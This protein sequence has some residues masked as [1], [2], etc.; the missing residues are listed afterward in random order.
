M[1]S[2][3][4]FATIVG[5]QLRRPALA[6]AQMSGI[7]G[8]VLVSATALLFAPA[9]LG[10]W[11]RRGVPE[12]DAHVRTWG[13]RAFRTIPWMM[14]IIALALFVSIPP[15]AEISPRRPAAKVGAALVPGSVVA[16]SMPGPSCRIRA[17]FH[18]S[19]WELRTASEFCPLARGDAIY[20]RAE[21]L[22]GAPVV[23]PRGTPAAQA[24]MR[25][26]V[27][28]VAR[29]SWVWRRPLGA[30]TPPQVLVHAW[31]HAIA[32]LRHRAWTWS[33]G[34]TGRSLVVGASLGIPAALSPEEV[35]VLRA[36][37]LSHLLAV[38]GLHVGVAFSMVFVSLLS[39]FGG[40]GRRGVEVAGALGVIALA[41]YVGLTGGAPSVVRAALSRVLVVWGYVR[42]FREHALQ[43]LACI[44][45]HCC[46]L[47]RGGSTVARLRA[48]RSRCV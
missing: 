29:V 21:E 16:A 48:G 1:A 42:G 9:V 2:A 22:V 20:V 4:L 26:G 8:V 24:A 37:G 27:H 6:A 17:S 32:T 14:F 12:T 47:D 41:A 15:A 46:E 5:F 40:A 35:G 34:E 30:S 28:R 36:A 44:R 18:G 31:S 23:L 33:R 43:R 25:I 45:S 11:G 3:V 7:A 19:I 38:S 39:V 13:A 10:A